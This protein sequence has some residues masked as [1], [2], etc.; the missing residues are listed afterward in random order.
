MSE[1]AEHG[2]Q[3]GD[4]LSAGGDDVVEG[5]GGLVVV[6]GVVAGVLGEEDDVGVGAGEG[7]VELAGDEGSLVAQGLGS[8]GLGPG[9]ARVGPAQHSGNP[10]ADEEPHDLGEKSHRH[11]LARVPG[12]EIPARGGRRDDQ[13]LGTAPGPQEDEQREP[14]C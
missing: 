6:V 7:V 4:G 10:Q 14:C 5:G 13:G 1:E 8:G 3:V 9:H 11:V 2:A 12:Q